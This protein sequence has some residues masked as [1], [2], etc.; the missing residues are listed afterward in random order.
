MIF[1][2]FLMN[3][4]NQNNPSVFKYVTVVSV[5]FVGKNDF[6]FSFSLQKYMFLMPMIN[7]AADFHFYGT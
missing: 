7:C 4:V 6:T 2:N 1:S 5:T 3:K